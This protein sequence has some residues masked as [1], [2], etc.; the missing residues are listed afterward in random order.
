M[1]VPA[2]PEE[3]EALMNEIAD[4]QE[5]G[6]SEPLIDYLRR[7]TELTNRAAASDPG[8]MAEVERHIEADIAGRRAADEAA[9]AGRAEPV[10]GVLGYLV[11]YR[12]FSNLIGTTHTTL[13]DLEGARWEAKQHGVSPTRRWFPVE[14][15]EVTGG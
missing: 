8:A 15:R 11:A 5:R 13:M 10:P 3:T 9:A 12:D 7:N 6:P 14:V 2:K 4:A 1:P